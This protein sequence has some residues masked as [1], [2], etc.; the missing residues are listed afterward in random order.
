MALDKKM[1]MF[2]SQYLNQ[3]I[4]YSH[5]GDIVSF[6]F[7]SIIPALRGGHSMF[8]FLVSAEVVANQQLQLCIDGFPELEALHTKS[9]CQTLST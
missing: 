6:V 4:L 5:N 8:V 9:L 2:S 1:H 7:I 3:H